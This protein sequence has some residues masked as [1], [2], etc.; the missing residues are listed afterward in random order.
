MNNGKILVVDDEPQIVGLYRKW[1]EAD[2]YD[3]STASSVP[4]AKE[5]LVSAAFD[6][7]L[8]DQRLPGSAETD[9]GLD[10]IT[11]AGLNGGKVFIVTGHASGEAVEKAFVRGAYDYL[12][13]ERVDVMKAVLRQ[14]VR[15][16][17]DMV[18][19]ERAAS[20]QPDERDALIRELWQK[21]STEAH[22][23]RKGRFLEQLL[24]ETFRM[25]PGF[26]VH[27]NERSVDEEFDLV[28]VNNAEDWRQES[29]YI[30]VEAKNWSSAVGPEHYDRF[31]RK[32]QRRAGRAN[33]GFFVATGGFTEGV[34]TSWE[35]DRRDTQL[36]V[37]IDAASLDRLVSAS[38]KNQVLHDLHREAVTR[39][40]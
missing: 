23:Q 6:V 13:K 15:R 7:V 28:I 9:A 17:L 40:A 14:K 31:F 36:V 26:T 32:L 16:A 33:L 22:A 12:T 3:V 11:E 24:T 10:L 20:R 37:L 21:V 8:L 30:L 4:E 1:L 27:P 39:S 5:A 38:D 18:A 25:I 2:G 34:R 29:P 35:S 19:A